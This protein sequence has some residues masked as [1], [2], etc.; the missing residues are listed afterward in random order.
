MLCLHAV[1]LARL[2]TMATHVLGLFLFCYFVSLLFFFSW[3]HHRHAEFPIPGT[4][5]MP[6]ALEAWSLNHWTTR[7]SLCSWFDLVGQGVYCFLERHSLTCFSVFISE[8]EGLMLF[9]RHPGPPG[10]FRNMGKE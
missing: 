6:P 9:I 1:N 5:P 8:G 3:P 7:K 2:C 4:E 10:I